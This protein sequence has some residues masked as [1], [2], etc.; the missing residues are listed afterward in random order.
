MSQPLIE[1]RNVHKTYIEKKKVPKQALIDISLDVKQGEILSLLGINGAGKTTLSSIIAT[2]YPPT[3]GEMLWEGNPI[4]SRLYDYR[5]II[6]FCPQTVNLDKHLT[7]EKILTF[8]GRLY[9]MSKKE[10]EERKEFILEKFQLEQ[11]VRGSVER[12]SGGYQRRFLLA[13]ALMHNPRLLILDEPTV[14]LDPQVRHQ[15][16]GLITSLRDDG[17]SILLTTHYLDEAEQLSDRVCILDQGV[18][19]VIDTASNLKEQLQKKNLEDV[20]LHLIQEN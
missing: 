7:L 11:Y 12:L 8:Q 10:I 6:G 5:K 18:I 20:F 15:L 2:L 9:G 1:L 19:K 13:R 16:W 17:Y 14:G 4:L 3:L